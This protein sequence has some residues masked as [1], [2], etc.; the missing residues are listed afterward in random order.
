MGWLFESCFFHLPM[1]GCTL[2][3]YFAAL[4]PCNMPKKNKHKFNVDQQPILVSLAGSKIVDWIFMLVVSAR[5][6]VLLTPSVNLL[7]AHATCQKKNKH[8]FNVDQ[9]PILVSLAGSKIVDWI[10]MLVVSARTRVL[11]TPSV[12]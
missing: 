2:F 9:Q 5:T 3:T 1:H 8:K 12:N 11:L 4:C 10:F 7:Y 6:R